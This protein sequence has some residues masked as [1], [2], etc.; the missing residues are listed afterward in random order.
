MT[1]IA[2][3]MRSDKS[4]YPLPVTRTSPD[5]VPLVPIPSGSIRIPRDL[6]PKVGTSGSLI[7]LDFQHAGTIKHQRGDRY[8]EH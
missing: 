1:Q 3:Y 5:A 2:S 6:F 4:Q 8:T 7:N